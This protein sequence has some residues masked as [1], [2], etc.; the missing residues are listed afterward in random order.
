MSMIHVIYL[1]PPSPQRTSPEQTDACENITFPQL[2]L[3]TV[4]MLDFNRDVFPPMQLRME[5][6]IPA[7]GVDR[8]TFIGSTESNLS[9][10]RKGLRRRWFI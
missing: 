6:L 2:L 8:I 10:Y 4:K 5:L 1:L 7:A 3:R 9:L